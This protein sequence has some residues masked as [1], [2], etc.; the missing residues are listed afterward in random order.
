VLLCLAALWLAACAGPP[1]RPLEF[2]AP[3]WADGETTLYDVQD[4]NGAPLG[5]AAWTL[6]RA[7]EG[8]AQAWTLNLA[9]R[10]ES[11]EVLMDDGLRPIRSWRESA[12]TRTEAEYAP[13]GVTVRATGPG[14]AI[15]EKTLP[16]TAD[17]LDNDQV[18]QAQR[19]LDLAEG[20]ATGYIDVIPSTV[21]AIPTTLR[22]AGAET[23]TTPAGSF[24]A[25]R[26]EMRAG[27][28]THD[29][30]YA[31]EPPYH[32]LKYRNRASGS[33]FLLRAV[34]GAELAAP[35]ALPLPQP[36]PA[37]MNVPL[38][39]AALLVQLPLMMLFPLFLGWWIRRR[40]GV[41]WGVF[42]AGA[43]TFIASQVVH[44]PL[45]YAL[46]LLGGGRG[47]ALWPL[48]PMALV[49]GLSAGICEEGARWLALTFLFKRIRTW[50]QGLQYGAGH[51]GVE[52]II[53]GALAL[54]SLVTMIALHFAGP[55]VAGLPEG[56]AGQVQAG[57]AAYWGQPWYLP[58]VGGF[59]R[60][61]A[62]TLQIAM[63]LLVVRSVARRQIGY[64]AAAI[65]LHTAVDAW[66]V[67]AMQTLGIAATEAG[68]AVMALGALWL[69][70][71]LREPASVEPPPGPAPV[72]ASAADL[73][74]Q[75]LSA[76]ELLRRVE[77]SKYE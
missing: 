67:W 55:A 74:P 64:L 24:P 35:G 61:F 66:A 8:W 12:G 69:I 68:V 45:N 72:V 60:V 56:A 4:R 48:V 46:G 26:T 41:G 15:R 16:S 53:F 30:W 63:A 62:I 33:V 57:A 58:I 51:G 29:A 7:A 13:G 47:V 52:A 27:G 28:S 2:K 50:S 34:G 43:L 23:I 49:A 73:T 38:L 18:L 71:R 1:P 25:W 40:Y 20:Y 21:S 17:A 9:G 75:A 37:A 14:G 22:V 3:P 70:F 44:L 77:A 39:L 19:A 54:V 42:W 65:A 6:R 76:E 5:S 36:A 11:G 32:L 31:Q 10:S 59:E